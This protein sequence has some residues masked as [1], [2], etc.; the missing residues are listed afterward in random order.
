MTKKNQMKTAQSKR[1]E[2]AQI[3][4]LKQVQNFAHMKKSL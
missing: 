2:I 3:F 1:E 4:S